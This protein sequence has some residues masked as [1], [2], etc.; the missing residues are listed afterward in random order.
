MASDLL[1]FAA[2]LLAGALNAAVGGGS[3][4]SIPAMVFAGLPSLAAN[5]SST[6]ALLPGSLASSWAWRKDLQSFEGVR[7]RTL[8]LIS[9][10]GGLAG[11]VLLLVTPP[12][13]F[14]RLLPW[15]LLTATLAFWLGR[16]AGEALRRRVRIGPGVILAAQVVL[17]IYAGY[18][19]GGV[20]IMMMAVWNLLGPMDMKAMSAGRTILVSAANLVAVLCFAAFGPVHWRET[21]IMLV[22]AIVGGYLGAILA[23]RVPSPTLRA[24]V[25]AF[26]VLMT[27]VFFWRAWA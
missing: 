21:A 11:A 27:G 3:F 10:A 13:A 19:G 1:L 7:L 6:V 15:L 26:G 25:L 23:R 16:R 4:V 8:L 18:F 17:S 22:A 5:A 2:G 24:F 14:D 9:L 20:G 12:R